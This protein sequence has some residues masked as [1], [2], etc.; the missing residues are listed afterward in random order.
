MRRAVCATP[1]VRLFLLSLGITEPDPVDDVV[2]NL[3]PK[4]QQQEVD[5]GD[6]AYA[7]DIEAHPAAFST[8]STAQK[9]SSG[10]PCAT[11]PL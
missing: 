8:D 9:E 7:A 6:D 3:L 4:Y 2:W 11:P 5:V 10:Q 1:E